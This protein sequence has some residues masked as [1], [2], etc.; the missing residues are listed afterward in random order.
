MMPLVETAAR[1]PP[2]PPGLKPLA[3]L[4]LPVWKPAVS[5]TTIVST[6]IATFHQVAALLV[7]V[8][9]RTLR[10]LIAV[11]IAISTI[12]AAIPVPVNTCWPLLSFIQCRANE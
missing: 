11:K 4:K 5:S 10:K 12:A 6:G 2:A 9:L 1:T 7:F 8:N 3:A